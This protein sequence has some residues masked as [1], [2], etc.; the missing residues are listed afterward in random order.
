[1]MIH[2]KASVRTSCLHTGCMRP[3]A[4]TKEEEIC[5]QAAALKKAEFSLAA[6]KAEIEKALQAR[7]T[8]K[9]RAAGGSFSPNL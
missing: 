9:T 1:M 4:A 2:R 3:Q 8:L 6:C 7:E 5:R